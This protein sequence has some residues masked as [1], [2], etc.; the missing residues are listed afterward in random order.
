LLFLW[1]SLDFEWSLKSKGRPLLEGSEDGRPTGDRGVDLIDR[2]QVAIKPK[3]HPLG[4]PAH[5]D[6][7]P[8]P[9]VGFLVKEADAAHES[10]PARMRGTPKS[11]FL[12]RLFLL[13]V[14][15][16]KEIR[17]VLDASPVG[18]VY[19]KID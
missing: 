8:V 14:K 17:T 11:P 9:A 15:N 1:K 4:G 16:G 13:I 3:V 7:F 19:S 6:C 2:S 5:I 18:A 12:L 10:L